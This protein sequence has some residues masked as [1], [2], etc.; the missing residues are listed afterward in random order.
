MLCL[1]IQMNPEFECD[2]ISIFLEISLPISRIGNDWNMRIINIY[3][4]GSS[5]YFLFLQPRLPV[6]R[7]RSRIF[8]F[9]APRQTVGKGR[10]ASLQNRIHVRCA[11]HSSTIKKHYI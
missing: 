10:I 1:E 4:S 11:P 7:A 5:N 3:A 9:R 6:D 8:H 2:R